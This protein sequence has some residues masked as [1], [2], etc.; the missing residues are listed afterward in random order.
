MI[1]ILKQNSRTSHS[2]VQLSSND[3]G[4]IPAKAGIKRPLVF[5]PLSSRLRRHDKNLDKNLTKQKAARGGFLSLLT[6]H[7]PSQP[8]FAAQHE[9][10]LISS[11]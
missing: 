10:N 4:V 2:A 8:R 11:E 3:H 5:T 1:F 6:L 9:R 7:Y